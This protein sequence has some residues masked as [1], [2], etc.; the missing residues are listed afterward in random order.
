MEYITTELVLAI[1]S[2]VL[3][4]ANI[5][6]QKKWNVKLKNTIKRINIVFNET[7]K[8]FNKLDDMEKSAN[9]TKQPIEI[10]KLPVR[11]ENALINN[12]VMYIEDLRN[13]DTEDLMLMRWLGKIAI[14]HIFKALNKNK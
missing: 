11:A 7:N 4:I 2:I 9:R 5:Y 14:E 1:W 10:L 13:I 6:V 8:K 3:L 12:N